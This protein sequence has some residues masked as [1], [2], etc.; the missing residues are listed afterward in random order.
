[1]PGLTS[2][3]RKTAVRPD[4]TDAHAYQTSVD[5]ASLAPNADVTVC[6]WKDPPELKARTT[7]RVRTFLKGHQ[8]M[9]A[10]R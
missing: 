1:M 10:A 9:T 3:S 4:D 5:V 2:R 8:S 6:P 7:N